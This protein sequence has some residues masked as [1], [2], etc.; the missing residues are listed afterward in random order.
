MQLTEKYVSEK[1]GVLVKSCRQSKDAAVHVL[2]RQ[3]MPKA[4]DI[5]PYITIYVYEK[6][7]LIPKLHIR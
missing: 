2:P 6:D 5:Q 7:Y 3:K 1:D 4:T